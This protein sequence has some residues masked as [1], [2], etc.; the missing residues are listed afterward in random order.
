MSAWCYVHMRWNG[1]AE[2]RALTACGFADSGEPPSGLSSHAQSY[3]MSPEGFHPTF[4]HGRV[5]DCSFPARRAWSKIRPPTT[6]HVGQ[7]Y[8]RPGR[9]EKRNGCTDSSRRP[10]SV[11][12][13]A[14]S[15]PRLDRVIPSSTRSSVMPF[16]RSRAAKRYPS[17]SFSRNR[18]DD[19]RP[20]SLP[21]GRYVPNRARAAVPLP[22]LRGGAAAPPPAVLLPL[23]DRAA[24]AGLR[25]P[26][27]RQRP[28]RGR[29]PRRLGRRPGADAPRSAPR[30]SGRRRRRCRRGRRSTTSASCAPSVP[31]SSRSITWRRSPSR[32]A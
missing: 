21:R 14:P 2:E 20:H 13:S 3:P 15:H 17:P 32:R 5:A 19:S 6:E 11:R 9:T 26:P 27:G 31:S 12:A 1:R 7:G 25:A 22:D 30:Q 28:R 24:A 4:A 10:D 18:E 23:P 8:G 29:T 16:S